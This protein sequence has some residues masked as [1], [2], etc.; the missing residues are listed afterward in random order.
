MPRVVLF[1]LI[2]LW[3]FDV[4]LASIPHYGWLEFKLENSELQCSA[5]YTYSVA[6]L[7][8]EACITYFIPVLLILICYALCFWKVVTARK[9]ATPKG[10]ILLEENPY[11][12]GDTYAEKI[13]DYQNKFKDAGMK[14]CKPKLG[15]R[16]FTSQGYVTD[17]DSD[18][19]EISAKE[20]RGLKKR[21]I[22]SKRDYS[23]TKTYVIITCVYVSLW[24]PY[25]VVTLLVN[26]EPYKSVPD[27]LINVF[28]CLTHFTL[29]AL[30]VVYF[31][32][33]DSFRRCLIKTLCGKRN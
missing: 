26:N 12:P 27:W 4:L 21:Y 33:N 7:V 1:L 29:F 17:S 25:V 32:H 8:F 11:S 24:L 5:D 10:E 3:L 30:P 23:L 19:N 16:K 18:V 20:E 15:N 13:S 9:N 6:T 2:G 14:K 28:T 31:L 22:L